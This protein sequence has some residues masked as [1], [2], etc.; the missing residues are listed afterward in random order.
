MSETIVLGGGCFWCLDAAYRLVEG[1]TE[2]T[3]GY[4]GGHTKDP[5]YWNVASGKTGHA[6]VVQVGFD[7]D[8]IKLQDILDIFWGM[9]DPTTL[10]YQGNDKG[11]EYRSIILYSTDKQKQIIDTSIQA[12]EKLW[13]NPIVTEVEELDIF[14]PAEDEHQ[15]FFQ[16]HPEQAYCQVIINPKLSK[17]RTKFK[18]HLKS[19]AV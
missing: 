8:I 18:T 3:S 10:N 12:V 11:T 5:D 9:H 7:P 16:K 13:D 4:A 2:V 6:E 14:Y 1:V 17:L 19:T 15:N